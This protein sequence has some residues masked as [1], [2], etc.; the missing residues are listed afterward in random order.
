VVLEY[1]NGFGIAINYNSIDCLAPVPANAKI[2]VGDKNLKP[3]GVVV[4]KE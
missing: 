2:L 1:R 3:A 4:W